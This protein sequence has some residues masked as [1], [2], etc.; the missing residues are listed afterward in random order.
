MCG[1]GAGVGEGVA[2]RGELRG[3]VNHSLTHLAVLGSGRVL[4]RGPDWTQ[5]TWCSSSSPGLEASS[6]QSSV[7]PVNPGRLLAPLPLPPHLPKASQEGQL[8]DSL[9][10]GAVPRLC[11]SWSSVSRQK[12]G[13][14]FQKGGVSSQMLVRGPLQGPELWSGGADREQVGEG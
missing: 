7:G 11:R 6:P 10:A 2:G 1:L 14:G 5:P 4:P 12:E 9:L 8:C 3:P 13:E